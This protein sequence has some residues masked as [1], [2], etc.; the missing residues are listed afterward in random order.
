VMTANPHMADDSIQDKADFVLL[1]PYDIQ[2]F[3][4]LVHKISLSRQFFQ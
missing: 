1:K 3:Q 2:E 4:T